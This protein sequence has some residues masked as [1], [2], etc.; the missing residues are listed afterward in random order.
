[1]LLPGP[2]SVPFR[3]FTPQE[4]IELAIGAALHTDAAI[5]LQL[6]S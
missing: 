6:L 4:I 3:L 5:S 1:M 2:C